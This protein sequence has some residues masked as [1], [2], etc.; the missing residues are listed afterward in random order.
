MG[1]FKYFFILSQPPQ[2]SI[3]VLIS[4][5]ASQETIVATRGIQLPWLPLAPIT[6]AGQTLGMDII[7]N[8]PVLFV[9]GVGAPG[10]LSL[11]G[12]HFLKLQCIHE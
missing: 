5:Q 11:Y 8:I 2:N 9:S 6:V 12:Y 7:P 4:A 1:L 10:S 3:S